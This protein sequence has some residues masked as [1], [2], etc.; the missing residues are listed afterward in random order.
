M[1]RPGEFKVL[2]MLEEPPL[3]LL[4]RPI[5]LL[6]LT[7]LISVGQVQP[8]HAIIAYCCILDE[9]YISSH[10]GSTWNCNYVNC[11]VGPPCDCTEVISFY[12][13]THDSTCM[14]LDEEYT[15]CAEYGFGYD[16]NDP[17]PYGVTETTVDCP[18]CGSNEGPCEN[19]FP[20]PA[21]VVSY[22]V[23]SEYCDWCC[24]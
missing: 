4:W 24:G 22:S 13:F 6:C 1:S 16:C 10:Y 23:P 18:A 12:Q 21:P 2:G 7:L 5:V 15:T 8:A 9:N 20:K 17:L 11:G 19:C 3:R 14:P